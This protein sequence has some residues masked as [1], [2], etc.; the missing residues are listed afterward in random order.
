[1]RPQYSIVTDVSTEPVDY[2]AAA[3]HLRVDS[4]DDTDYINGLVSVAR[5]YVDSLT[6]RMSAAITWKVIAE[7]WQDL[8][9]DAVEVSWIDPRY[10]LT[11]L[12]GSS[13]VIPLH[14]S[15][16]VSVSSIKYYAP[17]ADSLSTLSTD[18]YRVVTGAEP[19][20]VQL[21]ESPPE[22]DDRVDAIEIQFVAGAS[23][24]TTEVQK[25]AI[26]LMVA[27]L[28]ENRMHVAFASCQELS[29]SL[30]SL[31]VNQKKGGWF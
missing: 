18:N 6:G 11:G 16:L 19:G 31:I 17:D 20:I 29:H 1:M 9:D 5:E 13:Y 26:K 22:V 10:G 21:T 14:R 24:S 3:A 23:A 7:R 2:D 15:P 25:Q 4:T 8:F 30:Q 27:H 12:A 28:Y